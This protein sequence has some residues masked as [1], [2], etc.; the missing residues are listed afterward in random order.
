MRPLLLGH[1]AAAAAQL[2]DPKTASYVTEALRRKSHTVRWAA[3]GPDGF[4]PFLPPHRLRCRIGGRAGE[5]L[6]P[7]QAHPENAQ[8][9]EQKS[10]V[11]GQGAK[12]GR[13]LGRRVNVGD[14]SD[15]EVP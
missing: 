8:G 13:S 4:E 3:T 1:R 7:D 6:D 14:A 2:L 9:E 10:E 15:V 12:R 11:A 5:H